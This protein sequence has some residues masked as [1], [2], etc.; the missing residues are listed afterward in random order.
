MN[1]SV[2]VPVFVTLALM[3]SPQERQGAVAVRFSKD[4]GATWEA[5]SLAE[6]PDFRRFCAGPSSS[7][8]FTKN[9]LFRSRD[10]GKAWDSIRI[11]ERLSLNDVDID[12]KGT[13]HLAHSDGISVSVDDGKNWTLIPFKA[14]QHGG[15]SVSTAPGVVAVHDGAIFIVTA[16]GGLIIKR[17]RDSGKTWDAVHEAKGYIGAMTIAAKSGMI[18]A[19]ADNDGCIIGKDGGKTWTRGDKG[20]EG[21]N[22]GG[23]AIAISPADDLQLACAVVDTFRPRPSFGVYR[24]VD[25]GSSWQKVDGLPAVGWQTDGAKGWHLEFSGDGK[26]L[27]AGSTEGLFRVEVREGKL[28]EKEPILKA[29]VRGLGRTGDALLVA[30][31]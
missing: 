4:A 9:S 3:G 28:R 21:I 25:G 23:G 1:S 19:L 29:P 10:G 31:P 11:P 6:L 26:T 22:V 16:G 12:A 14:D 13:I 7:F 20:I 5:T 27:F 8:L 18:A 17:S 24:S 15:F 30:S 2:L